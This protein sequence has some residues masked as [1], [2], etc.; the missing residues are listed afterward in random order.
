MLFFL[1]MKTNKKH[2]SNCAK[3]VLHF[4]AIHTTSNKT[5]NNLKD[6][7]TLEYF[8]WCIYKDTFLYKNKNKIKTC[9][10]PYPAFLAVALNIF[11]SL[12]PMLH[13]D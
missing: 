9:F 6:S 10:R 7:L 2:M 1:L 3:R 13:S 11:L 8:L 4:F 12:I 5:K